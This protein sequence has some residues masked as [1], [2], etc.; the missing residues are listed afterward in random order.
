MS[1]PLH[2]RIVTRRFTQAHV[3]SDF[4]NILIFNDMKSNSFYGSH[5]LFV[6]VTFYRVLLCLGYR[7]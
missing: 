3:V 1:L 7:K 4:I 5:V 2:H 6:C